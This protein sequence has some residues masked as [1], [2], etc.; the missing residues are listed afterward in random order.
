M[1]THERQLQLLG[2]VGMFH[3]KLPKSL[4]DAMF[5]TFLGHF[6]E[7]VVRKIELVASLTGLISQAFSWP[8]SFS[9]YNYARQRSETEI[10]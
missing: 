6:I 4:T 5:T 10:Q 7:I 2:G 1:G 9:C 3:N 8:D